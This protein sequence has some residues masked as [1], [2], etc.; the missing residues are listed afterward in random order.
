MRAHGVVIAAGGLL[1]VLIVVAAATPILSV[2]R[3]DPAP[4]PISSNS[5]S[6][7]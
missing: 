7:P 5:P 1:L 4:L 3:T 2:R 6:K